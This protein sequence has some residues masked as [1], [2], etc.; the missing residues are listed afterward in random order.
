MGPDSWGGVK[1]GWGAVHGKSQEKQHTNPGDGRT[2]RAG[3]SMMSPGLS[4]QVR[5]L[6]S[7]TR[8]PH[9]RETNVGQ[10]SLTPPQP[11]A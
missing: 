7:G 2:S 4:S 5:N 8:K 1:V 10:N 3:G 6:G 9:H 11:V